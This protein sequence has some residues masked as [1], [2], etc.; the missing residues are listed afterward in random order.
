MVKRPGSR[1]APKPSYGQKIM[2]GS[3]EITIFLE[4]ER[5][6]VRTQMFNFSVYTPCHTLW[7]IDIIILPGK[8][9]K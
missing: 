5:L 2:H 7:F 3:P 8:A 9:I 1:E 6:Y 4:T